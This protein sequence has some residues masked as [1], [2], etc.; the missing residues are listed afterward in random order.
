MHTMAGTYAKKM[1]NEVREVFYLD[2]QEKEGNK[3]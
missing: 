3:G 1:K 2:D